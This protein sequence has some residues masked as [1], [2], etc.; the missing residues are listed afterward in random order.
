L[1]P[2]LQNVRLSW[3]SSGGETGFRRTP[4]IWRLQAPDQGSTTVGLISVSPQ[5]NVTSKLTQ[6]TRVV[7]NLIVR[8]LIKKFPTGYRPPI[9]VTVFTTQCHLP[10]H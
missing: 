9:F 6:R 1:P 2:R 8:H 10:P 7:E 3:C 5:K 4:L